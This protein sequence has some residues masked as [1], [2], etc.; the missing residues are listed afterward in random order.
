VLQWHVIPLG[1]DTKG[2]RYYLVPNTQTYNSGRAHVESNYRIVHVEEDVEGQAQEAQ[3]ALQRQ[4]EQKQREL[5]LAKQ[6]A[7]QGDLDTQLAIAKGEAGQGYHS[8]ELSF[9]KAN[10]AFVVAVSD[11][12][13]ANNH[14][15][16]S[17]IKAGQWERLA[18]TKAPSDF[19]LPK[20]I[21][22]A[23]NPDSPII[24]SELYRETVAAA[25][26]ASPGYPGHYSAG[27]NAAAKAVLDYIGVKP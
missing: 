4:L 8:I 12:E 19:G 16:K 22:D 14:G 1:L 23:S 2:R 20:P 3:D 18:G 27:I 25:S 11:Y 26:D 15:G 7:K 24:A 21:I 9:D 10:N 6:A 5:D 13:S 17:A